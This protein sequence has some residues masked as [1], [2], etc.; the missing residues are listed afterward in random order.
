MVVV[1]EV[2]SSPFLHSALAGFAL[3]YRGVGAVAKAKSGWIIEDDPEYARIIA[4][5]K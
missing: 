2:K 3:S 1:D 5:L 4:A